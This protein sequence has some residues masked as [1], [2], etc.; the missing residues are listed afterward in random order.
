MQMFDKAL[1][2]AWLLISTVCSLE[3]TKNRID[4]GSINLGNEDIT[5]RSGAFWSIINNAGTNF[6]SNINVD[7]GGIFYVSS[8]SPQV[9]LSVTL[10]GSYTLINNGVISLNAIAG[11]PNYNFDLVGTSM[12]NNGDLFLSGSGDNA[13]T[14]Y[15]KATDWENY[16]LIQVYQKKRTN[17]VVYLGNHGLYTNNYGQICLFN[18]LWQQTANILGTGCITG[19]ANSSFYLANTNLAISSQQTMYMADGTT[20]IVAVGSLTPLTFTVKGFGQVDGVSNKIGLSGTLYS[21]TSGKN[22]WDYNADTGILTLYVG[23]YRQNFKIGKG[24]DNTKFSVV[25]D[26]ALGLPAPNLGSVVYNG[27]VPEPGLPAACKPCKPIPEIPGLDATSY[28]TTLRTTSDG[29]IY[30]DNALVAISTDTDGIFTTS[31]LTRYPQPEESLFLSTWTT[32]NADGS[33]ETDSGL[34]T[35]SGSSFSTILTIPPPIQ[36]QF[37]KTWTTT[38]SEGLKEVDSGLVS[39]S[40]NS[41]TTLSTFPPVQ[42][43]FTS[44]WTTTHADGSVE[45]G[46]GLVS[47]SGTSFTTLTTFEKPVETEFTSTWTTTHADGSVETGSGLVSQ[48]GTS[49]TTL[50]TFEKPVETE[51]TSTW[52]TTHADGSV[53]TGSGL[54]S[55]SGTSFT[56]L[57]TFVP[58]VETEFTSTWTTTHADGSV[59]TGSGLVSQSGTSFTTLSTFVPVQTEFTSTWTTTHADGSVETGSGLVSQ[60]GTSFT[61]LTTFEKPVE[62]EFTSTWTTTHADGSVATDQDL[63]HNSVLRSP[64]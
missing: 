2:L 19:A 32:T 33:V 15:M 36:T 37:T 29:L 13:V 42:T 20:S 43:E 3:I 64:L 44:T 45:T 35:Q 46:S 39:Q 55:Q 26:N 58:D 24:Y 31:T 5:I 52:T 53:E 50:T 40:G 28:T 8:V 30:T 9:S 62:T 59:E 7:E 27:P 25:T 61:T 11:N 10:L 18:Q 38:D 48:S 23:D 56:T 1:L 47:Q 4:R 60:S 22:P 41:F 54:V 12:I 17:G 63:C 57:S 16:G 51:F 14:V 21:S 49:F 6:N 34:I